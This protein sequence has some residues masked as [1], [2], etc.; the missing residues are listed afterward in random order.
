MCIAR[1]SKAAARLSTSFQN[2]GD[3]DKIYHAVVAGA[4]YGSGIREDLLV[5]TKKDNGAMDG[6]GPRTRVLRTDG[7]GNLRGGGRV[8]GGVYPP[9]ASGDVNR[10]DHSVR[11]RFGGQDPSTD[12]VP[13][14]GRITHQHGVDDGDFMEKKEAMNSRSPSPTA[15]GDES[16]KG[17]GERSAQCAQGGQGARRMQGGKRAQRAVLEW[18]AICHIPLTATPSIFSL[19]SEPLRND[20]TTSTLVRVRLVTGR[21]HQIRAQ[22][23][24]MGHPIIGDVRYGRRFCDHYS[25]D[26]RGDNGNGTGM[27][28]ESVGTMMTS[29]LK[30]RCIMLHASELAVPHPTRH[31]E[32]VRVRAQPPKIWMEMCGKKVLERVFG[33]SNGL[34][35]GSR[36]HTAVR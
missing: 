19:F 11:S 9:T 28:L 24:G 35:E 23:A 13:R 4:L 21:K 6:R 32:V 22:L 20:V 26:H 25:Y 29:P 34:A 27:Y 10:T 14:S 31:G 12:E 15:N 16:I 3:V 36:Q 5:P 33:S 7:R 18:E 1:T 30:D 2:R 8:G 17:I